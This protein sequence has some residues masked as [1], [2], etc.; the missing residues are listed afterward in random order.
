MQL[1][2]VSPLLHPLRDL[3]GMVNPQVVHDQENLVLQVVDQALIGHGRDHRDAVPAGRMD[4]LQCLPDERVAANPARVLADGGLVGPA[5]RAVLRLGSL[6]DLRVRLGRSRLQRRRVL[7]VSA[8]GRPLQRHGL[9]HQVFFNRAVLAFHAPSVKRRH[10]VC[11]KLSS[12]KHITPR[13]DHY[14]AQTDAI[15]SSN[16]ALSLEIWCA[17]VLLI[18]S[19]DCV[20]CQANK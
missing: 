16:C 8:Q 3:L 18:N 9:A 4:Q 10:I 19:V 11:R 5:G 7:L 15:D 6:D 12:I 14:C 17:S 13:P 20:F 1:N 2:A